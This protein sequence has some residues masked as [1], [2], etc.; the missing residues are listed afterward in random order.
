[1]HDNAVVC[2][3]SVFKRPESQVMYCTMAWSW[4]LQLEFLGT[5]AMPS[6]IEKVTACSGRLIRRNGSISWKC[7]MLPAR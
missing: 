6:D 1:M 2:S 3:F 7:K 5:L 4:T